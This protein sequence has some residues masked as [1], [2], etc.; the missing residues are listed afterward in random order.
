MGNQDFGYCV[1]GPKVEQLAADDSRNN[2]FYDCQIRRVKWRSKKKY[3]RKIPEF[4]NELG[5]WFWF[6]WE[7]QLI[8]EDASKEL[9]K[10]DLA[11]SLGWEWHK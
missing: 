8:S 4:W 7:L 9:I 1:H 2:E 5:R 6:T 11:M 3:Q 10:N